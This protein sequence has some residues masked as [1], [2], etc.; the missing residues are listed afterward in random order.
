MKILI[1][2]SSLTSG[3]AEKV[4]TLMANYWSRNHDVTLLT[5]DIPEN[6]FFKTND[7]I[8]RISTYFRIDTKNVPYKI[9]LHIKGLKRLRDIVINEYPDIIISHMDVTNVRMLLATLC[10]R[11]PI[12]VEDHNN[13][14]LKGMPQPWAFLKP[15]TYRFA[16]KIVL[17]TRDL[18]NYYPKKLYD[19]SKI[20]FIPNPLNLPK[21]ISDSKEV[22]VKK[23][24]FIALGSLTKQKGFD[25][26]IKA[27][28]D[29]LKKQSDWNLMIL[30]EGEQRK[31]LEKLIKDLNLS[32]KVSLPG[33][34]KNPYSILK[35]ADIYV[36]SSRFEGFPVALCEAMGVGLPCISFDCPTGPADIIQHNKNGLLVEY[37]NQKQLTEA[38]VML[39]SNTELKQR[40]SREAMKINNTLEIGTIM[41]KWEELFASDKNK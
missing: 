3:G 8:K 6:D 11:I 28:K 13:P 41:N 25:I 31:A 12:I 22:Q 10:L 17:L 21:S 38:M 35:K 24:S 29:V 18:L 16:S 39:A 9:L 1:Y 4:A 7:N 23:P 27:F 32:E 19:H 14:K 15:F 34:V 36:M 26:L 2:I 20:V 40:F 37:L 30:G 5:D 33:R